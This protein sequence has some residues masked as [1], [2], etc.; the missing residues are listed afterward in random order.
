M[1]R[2]GSS[3]DPITR[4][5]IA[6]WALI[7]FSIPSP[8]T[9]LALGVLVVMVLFIKD[10]DLNALIRLFLRLKYVLLLIWLFY[11][12][13]FRVFS[14]KPYMIL[15][16]QLL[17]FW[18]GLDLLFANQSYNEFSDSLERIHVPRGIARAVGTTLGIVDRYMIEM[19]Q[20]LKYQEIRGYKIDPRHPLKTARTLHR[21]FIPLF[22]L[23]ILRSKVV[24]AALT[25]KNWHPKVKRTPYHE[26]EFQIIDWIVL[27]ALSVLSVLRVVS[28][29]GFIAL[30]KFLL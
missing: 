6:L 20:L 26:Y 9:I 10:R 14:I 5:I 2:D 15:F 1:S 8:A 11:F 23:A 22:S 4:F 16:F 19:T 25:S 27:L 17:G 13:Y 21:I 12:L 18:I 28:W 3:L 24:A 7:W 30:A 29:L